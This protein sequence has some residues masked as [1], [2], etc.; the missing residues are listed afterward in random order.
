MPE[1]S[2]QMRER[3]TSEDVADL[4]L[5]TLD[6]LRRQGIRR[7]GPNPNE[8]PAGLI[9]LADVPAQRIDWLWR[10]RLARKKITVLDGDPGL[11]KSTVTL[12]IAA[13]ISTGAAFP[14]ETVTRPPGSVLILSAEDD[15]AD[16]LRPRADA[17]GGDPGRICIRQFVPE[18][19]GRLES[20]IT[21]RPVSIPEDIPALEADIRAFGADLLII[22]PFVAY[23]PASI[24]SHKDQDVRRALSQFK[25][26]A[27][28]T[29]IAILL[30]RHLSKAVGASALMR[31]GGS[32]GIIGAARF[33]LLVARDPDDPARR[34]IA[35]TKSN[36]A[37]ESETIAYRLE[38][39]EGTDVARV[40]WDG[41]SQLR[42]DELVRP[43]ED[44][45]EK[46]DRSFAEE[47]LR[48]TLANGSVPARDIER[49]GGKA[50]L[51]PKMLRTARVKL[52]VVVKRVGFGSGSHIDWS[53]P[54][55]IHADRNPIDALDAPVCIP[56]EPR[57]SRASMSEPD[58][59]RMEF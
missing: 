45:A 6:D 30:I 24:D 58:D 34:L 43:P 55:P 53:L 12:D 41:T 52:G 38:S 37:I 17:A 3:Q 46:Q 32:V 25:N 35:T 33:G 50:G 54:D 18:W 13:R 59:D 20:P 1:R 14:G 22:D 4:A 21:E 9:R 49:D 16:T 8:M 31:G 29:G 28:R 36:L 5:V 11:G 26:L 56:R 7:F 40:V 10:D 51:T 15:A 44:E 27:E 39:V 47:W 57:A 48:E 19:D 42:A 23:L 2:P